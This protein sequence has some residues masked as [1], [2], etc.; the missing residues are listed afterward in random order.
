MDENG[1]VW[2]G[3]INVAI[4]ENDSIQIENPKLL[5]SDITIS[6]PCYWLSYQ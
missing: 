1:N 4:Y 5:I 2:A 6:V 3:E